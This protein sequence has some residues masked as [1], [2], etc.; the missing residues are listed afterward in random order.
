MGTH[1]E[2]EES[3][4]FKVLLVKEILTVV[5]QLKQLHGKPRNKSEA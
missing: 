1:V 2:V 3:S 5:K 4:N